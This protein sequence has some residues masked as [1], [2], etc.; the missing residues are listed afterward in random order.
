MN[1]TSLS[2]GTVGTS[3]KAAGS[4]GYQN[5]AKHLNKLKAIKFKIERGTHTTKV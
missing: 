5:A 2:G 3:L 1:E 4:S